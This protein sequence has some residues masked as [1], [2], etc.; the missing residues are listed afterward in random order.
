M[1]LQLNKT[2]LHNKLQKL[3]SQTKYN[4]LKSK[5]LLDFINDY[6]IFL[7]KLN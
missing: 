1:G 5:T 7:I 2:S 4:S 6:V 3:S